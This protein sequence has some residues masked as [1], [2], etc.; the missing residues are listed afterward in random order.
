MPSPCYPTDFSPLLKGAKRPSS[1]KN[2]HVAIIVTPNGHN[3]ELPYAGLIA[4]DGQA[5][6]HSDLDELGVAA[7][8]GEAFMR[9]TAAL[10]DAHIQSTIEMFGNGLVSTG[11]IVPCPP[12]PPRYD[13]SIAGMQEVFKVQRAVL[14]KTFPGEQYPS[15][16]PRP[17]VTPR[18]IAQKAAKTPVAKA[19]AVKAPSAPR[20][21]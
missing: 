13:V 19:A 7:F 21:G 15:K 17:V 3:K 16:S 10:P 9:V 18:V 5:L 20:K 2:P 4:V 6:I 12:R 8:L 14:G 1:N 11:V